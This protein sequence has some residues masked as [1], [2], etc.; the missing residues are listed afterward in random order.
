VTSSMSS[1]RAGR[2]AACQENGEAAL[3]EGLGPWGEACVGRVKLKG[4]ALCVWLRSGE[5]VWRG[6]L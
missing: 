5:S 2:F 4:Y 6:E 1:L 3:L